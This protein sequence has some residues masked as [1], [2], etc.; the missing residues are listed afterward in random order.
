MQTKITMYH[1]KYSAEQKLNQILTS[2][3]NFEQLKN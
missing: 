1:G 3:V 2:L